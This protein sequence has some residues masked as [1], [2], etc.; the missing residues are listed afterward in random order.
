MKSLIILLSFLLFTGCF[1]IKKSVKDILSPAELQDPITE[2]Q[3]NRI[4]R[5]AERAT[6]KRFKEPRKVRKARKKLNNAI[7]L[8]P[9]LIQGDSITI[10]STDTITLTVKE[11][12]ESATNE[13]MDDLANLS[14]D[15]DKC[16]RLYREQINDSMVSTYKITF[17]YLRSHPIVLKTEEMTQFG[18]IGFSAIVK[19]VNNELKLIATIDTS[20]LIVPKVVN[21]T[22]S[23]AERDSFYTLGVVE[24]TTKEIGKTNKQ[25][26]KKRFWIY[27]ALILGG[28]IL[29][30]IL[31]FIIG[32]WIRPI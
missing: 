29:I 30:R 12:I 25:R 28:I 23:I 2:K 31:I 8:D 3:A 15:C 1:G 17:D 21:Y 14:E 9:K 32:K 11:I 22:L 26:G 7:K 13:F 18:K 20:F 6:N 4:E 24:G 5:R 27:V 16:I 10:Y 19:V